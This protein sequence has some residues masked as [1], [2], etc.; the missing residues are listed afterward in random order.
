MCGV[1]KD[2]PSVQRPGKVALQMITVI[3][4][5]RNEIKIKTNAF[6]DGGSD[7]SYLKDEIADILGLET[8]RRPLRLSV[9]GANAVVTDSKTVTVHLESMDGS[10]KR[11]AF[12]WT[13]PNICEMKAV[14]WSHRARSLEDW[15]TN[16]NIVESELPLKALRVQWNAE[17]DMFNFKLNPHR[18]NCTQSKGS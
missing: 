10:T 1:I 2:T 12:L 8:E 5:G 18:T 4:E 15:V 17:T 7:S 13:T 9:F 16:V 3:L 14:D 11:E 6:I